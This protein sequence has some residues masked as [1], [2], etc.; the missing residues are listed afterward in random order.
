VSSKDT[1]GDY[2]WRFLR[3]PGIPVAFHWTRWTESTQD[4][5]ACTRLHSPPSFGFQVQGK[6][7]SWKH[8]FTVHCYFYTQSAYCALES[9]DQKNHCTVHIYAQSLRPWAQ[10]L[11]SQRLKRKRVLNIPLSKR[12]RWKLNF[13]DTYKNVAQNQGTDIRFPLTFQ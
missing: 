12:R 8:L 5:L 6:N 9:G 11:L 2:L 7:S 1:N 13:L 10:K 4:L 3:W